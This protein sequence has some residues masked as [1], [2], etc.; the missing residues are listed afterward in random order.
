MS[1]ALSEHLIVAVKFGFSDKTYDF[2]SDIPVEV[3]QRV[4]VETSRGETKATVTEIKSK[5]DRAE[6]SVLRIVEPE[7]PPTGEAA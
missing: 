5:S 7:T 3:G 4:Y 6:R 2:F 1:D